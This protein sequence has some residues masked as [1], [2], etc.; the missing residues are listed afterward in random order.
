MNLSPNTQAILLLTSYFNTPQQNDVKPLTNTEWGRFAQWLKAQAMTPAD[1]LIAD[2]TNCLQKWHDPHISLERLL[3][4][5]QRGHALAFALEKWQRAGLWVI[6][7]SDP[8]YPKRLKLRLTTNAPPIFFG[9]GNKALLNAGGLAVVGSRHTTQ[10]DLDFTAQVGQQAAQ[11]HIPII[12]GGAQGV[13]QAAMQS[14]IQQHGSAIGILAD[15]LLNASV[16]NKWRSG[17][18]AGKCVLIS[19][20]YPEA[21]FHVGHA[22]ARNKYIYCLAEQALVIHAHQKGGTIT[23][24]LENLKAQWVPLWVKHTVDLE[25]ANQTLVEQG[26]KWCTADPAQFNIMTLFQATIP[27]APVKSLM[28]SDLFTQDIFD[29]ETS[30][31]L[32]FFSDT[33]VKPMPS[34][35]DCFYTLF[36]DEIK[37][38]LKM[39]QTEKACLDFLPLHKSQLRQWL[40]RAILD[41]F[42]QKCIIKK[43]IHYRWI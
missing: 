22:M 36:L 8:E 34:P 15:N 26:G 10:E 31:P 28:S 41:G 39:P 25:A 12:S 3:Q 14:A 30:V 17:L 24:A 29:P 37:Q 18:M 9:C 4:L 19:A 13:D 5:L 11:A 1:L 32:S 16:S 27:K 7:R 21:K 6:T 40:E 42:I 38:H 23:G 33:K 43:R 35:S 2:P 20:T